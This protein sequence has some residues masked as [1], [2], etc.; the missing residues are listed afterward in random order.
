[1]NKQTLAEERTDWAE[2]RTILANERTFAGWM[3]TGMAS[4]AV[5]IGLQAVFG[6]IEPTWI[7]KSAASIFV[8]IALIVFWAAWQNAA[9]MISR[10]DAHVAEPVSRTHF[11][12]IA[13]IMG[14]GSL[15]SGIVLW[16]V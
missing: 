11:K 16:M 10:L 9:K 6:A 14:V 3:R 4:L 13:G 8:V 1:M 15:A 12:L 5:G 2:D 7:A